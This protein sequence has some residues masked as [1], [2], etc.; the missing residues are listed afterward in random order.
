[1]FIICIMYKCK[2]SFSLIK[3]V[4]V[5]KSCCDRLIKPVRACGIRRE[6]TIA[7][8]SLGSP[9]SIWAYKNL[10]EHEK[11]PLEPAII[12]CESLTEP[13]R[14]DIAWEILWEF[15]RVWE[16]LQEPS[17]SVRAL[18]FYKNAQERVR[19]CE[20][21]W[22]L[23]EPVREYES[24]QEYARANESLWES[25]RACK[26]WREFVRGCKS[27][28]DLWKLWQPAIACKI[29]DSL[30]EPGRSHVSLQTPLRPWWSPRDRVRSCESLWEFVRVYGSL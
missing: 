20:S 2:L 10:R 6:L 29:F 11:R 16:F 27:L 15:A 30:Q 7:C 1:M 13:V 22:T 17:E 9:E 8:E 24:M 5:L 23:Q 12:A 21:L 3:P 25:A 26:K 19:P 14:P 18:R 28:W 4:K